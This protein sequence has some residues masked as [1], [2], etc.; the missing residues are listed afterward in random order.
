LEEIDQISSRLGHIE[1]ELDFYK[2]LRSAEDPGLL[3]PP[4]D[5]EEGA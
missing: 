3:Q 5:D 4:T 1:E 2:E